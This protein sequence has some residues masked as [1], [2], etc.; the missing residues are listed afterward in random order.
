V[1][2]GDAEGVIRLFHDEALVL[3]DGGLPVS[4]KAAIAESWR[5]GTEGGFLLRDVAALRTGRSG[6]LAFRVNQY[7]WSMA[8]PD[9]ER[10][11][12]P[13]KN[14]HI[15]KRE[16]DGSWKLLVDLWNENPAG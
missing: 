12:L 3:P 6:D 8:E 1:E 15:W 13:T 2:A 16:A 9:S 7:S 14:I 4:G 10:T 5:A 11:W